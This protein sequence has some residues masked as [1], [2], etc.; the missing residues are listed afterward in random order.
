MKKNDINSYN[1][2]MHHQFFDHIDIPKENV[3]IPDGELEREDVTEF[4]ARYE[5]KISDV[6]GIDIQILGIGR[7]G[8]I[9][10]N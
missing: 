7:V 2:Y 9:G 4:C 10:F 5:K 1:Y 3:N 8:H 6:K